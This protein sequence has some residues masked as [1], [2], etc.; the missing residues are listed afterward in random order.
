MQHISAAKSGTNVLP[1]NLKLPKT[2]DTQFMS[3]T[4]VTSEIVI[5]DFGQVFMRIHVIPG[6]H[7]SPGQNL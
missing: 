4:K 3:A 5:F 7:E 1:G 6:V 2:C